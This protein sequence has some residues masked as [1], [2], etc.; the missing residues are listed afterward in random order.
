MAKPSPT[1]TIGPIHFED[2]ESHRF[3]DLVRQL[4]YDFRDWKYLEPTGRTGSDDGFDAR[5]VERTDR[6]DSDEDADEDAISAAEDRV[7]LIQCKREK[8]MTPRKVVEYLEGLPSSSWEHLYGIVF[9]APSDFSKTTRDDFRKVT[10]AKGVAE[11]RIWGKGEIEDMLFQPKNDHLLFAYFGISLQMRRRS[12]A[13]ELRSRLS[14]KRKLTRCLKELRGEAVL[15]RDATDERYPFLDEATG[16]DRFAAGRWLLFKA[17][18]CHHDGLHLLRRRHFAFLDNDNVKWDFAEKMNDALVREDPWRSERGD[19][20]SKARQEAHEI[21][22]KLG[23]RNRG[24][25]ELFLVL[26][27]ENILA[28]DED[29]DDFFA[30]PHIYTVEASSEKSLFREFMRHN[31]ARREHFGHGYIEPVDG[32]RVKVFPRQGEPTKDPEPYTI[33]E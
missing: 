19:E 28:V 16:K 32:N 11:A 24:W 33:D 7:W 2:L 27:Y 17:D 18:G 13:T 22:D 1:R 12:L 6:P 29:G 8:K 26:P 5:G 4:A 20:N 25:F 9:A 15:I 31:L 30:G 14:T 21:W 3:E 23:D 10:R